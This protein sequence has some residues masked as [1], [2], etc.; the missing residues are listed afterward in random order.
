MK[1]NEAE[2]L[3]EVREYI[4]STYEGHY[5]GKDKIQ[6]IDVWETLNIEKEACLANILKYTM[7]YGKKD[8]YN[9]KDLLKIIHYTL[10]LWHFTQP[11]EDMTNGN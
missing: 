5:V 2:L 3:D 10:M 1:F 11:K 4:T 7:R 9:K 6:T 8:G